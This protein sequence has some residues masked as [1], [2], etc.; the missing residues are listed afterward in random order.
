MQEFP[1]KIWRCYKFYAL[2]EI[3]YNIFVVQKGKEVIPMRLY[4]ILS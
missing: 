2:V 4:V 3:V 1:H